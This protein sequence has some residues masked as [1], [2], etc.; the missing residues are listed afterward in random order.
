MYAIRLSKFREDIQSRRPTRQEFY[1]T[2]QEA[3]FG[4]LQF[5]G[6]CQTNLGKY[7]T[8][9]ARL[10]GS[11]TRRTEYYHIAANSRLI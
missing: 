6:F 9:T 11:P 10:R 7:H 8:E 1:A 5:G 2:L 4:R 3:D